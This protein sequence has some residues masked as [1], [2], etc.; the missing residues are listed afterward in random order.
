MKA[1]NLENEL[2]NYG[3]QV[4]LVVEYTGGVSNIEGHRNSTDVHGEHYFD[5]DGVEVTAK[6]LGWFPIITEIEDIYPTEGKA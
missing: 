6:I 5:N 2:P 1:K 4:M 3:E